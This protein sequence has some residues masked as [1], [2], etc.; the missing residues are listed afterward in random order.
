MMTISEPNY[1]LF[2][3]LL[4]RIR[5]Y[6]KVRQFNLGLRV[7]L[8]INGNSSTFV[9]DLFI[10][11]S[12]DIWISTIDSLYLFSDKTQSFEHVMNPKYTE[13]ETISRIAEGPGS[14][15]IAITNAGIFVIDKETMM[16]SSPMFADLGATIVLIDSKSRMW[17]G[18]ASKGLFISS[19]EDAGQGILPI[20]INKINGLLSDTVSKIFALVTL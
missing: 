6:L 2:N 19:L 17:I 7:L 12:K 20:N 4:K 13:L 9:Q 11:T 14:S 18:T 16:W 5:R 8:F 3:R 15:I 10:D 1:K